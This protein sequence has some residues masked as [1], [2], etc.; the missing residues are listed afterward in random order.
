M[1]EFMEITDTNGGSI[2]AHYTRIVVTIKGGEAIA[3][4]GGTAY[5]NLDHD[6][7]GELKEK[8]AKFPLKK[9]RFGWL[10]WWFT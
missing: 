9:K 1:S 3:W 10:K 2:F 8:L 4:V 6:R 7:V 5:V